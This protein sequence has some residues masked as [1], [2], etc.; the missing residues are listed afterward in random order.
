MKQLLTGN[1]AVAIGAYE[2]GVQ[3]ASGY[4]GTPSTEI[5]ET[6]ANFKE[7]VITEWATNEKVAIEAVI[8]ASIVGARS[9]AAMKHVGVNV[10]ADPLFT[11]SYTGVN[12]GMVLVSADE[13]G[14]H[15]SQNEQDNRNYAKFAKIAMLEPS[16]SQEAY[17]MVRQAF[18]ISEKF[19]TPVLFRMTTRVCHSKSVV[20]CVGDGTPLTVPMRP[21]VKNIKKNIPVP[22]IVIGL[23]IAVQHRLDNLR[24]FSEVTP[25]NRIVDNKSRIGVITSGMCFHYAREVFGTTASYLKLGYTNPL[26]PVLIRRFAAMVDVLYVI[27]ENDPYIESFV[28]EQ[29]VSCIGKDI[30]PYTGEMTG[31]TIRKSLSMPEIEALISKDSEQYKSAVVPRPP[32]LCAGCPHRGIFYELGKLKNVIVSGDIGCYCLGFDEPYNAI[33]FSICMGASISC[34]HGA[35]KVLSRFGDNTK[36]VFTVL[37]DSTFFHTGINSLLN[38]VYNNSATINL[39]LD[40][41]ITGMTGHQQ[42]PGTGYTLQNDPAVMVDMEALVKACGVRNIKVIN[43]N[44]LTEVKQAFAWALAI[45]DAPSV[46]ITKWP[47]VL[48]KLTEQDKND[49]PKVFTTKC[50]VDPNICIGCRK[51]LKSGCPAISYSKETRKASIDKTQCVACGVCGQICP[52]GAIR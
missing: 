40:N 31:D 48:K 41:R 35:Q 5:L 36:R 17:D 39:I 2:A 3:F 20:E 47:C 37:G 43:P 22:S 25:L 24:Q 34:G 12:G 38:T 18:D 29:G 46:I 9:L 8:G 14:H 52:V 30:F 50:A 10:A 26:P 11:F 42:N 16:D 21:Y 45:T 49:F 51:C 15:S 32:V 27:E 44:N 13:P 23:R 1:E 33:D 4:P 19:N 6:L 28:K 7:S